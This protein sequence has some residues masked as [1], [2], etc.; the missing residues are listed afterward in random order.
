MCTN[1][2]DEAQNKRLKGIW[3]TGLGGGV[4][5]HLNLAFAV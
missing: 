3:P 4:F 5:I 2:E 1:H